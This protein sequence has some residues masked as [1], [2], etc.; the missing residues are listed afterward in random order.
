MNFFSTSNYGYVS[1]QESP[2][3]AISNPLFQQSIPWPD[4]MLDLGWSHQI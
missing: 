4:D 2:F 1:N 3:Y